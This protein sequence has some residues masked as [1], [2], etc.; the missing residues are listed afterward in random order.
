MIATLFADTGSL[1]R[2]LRNAFYA[3]EQSPLDAA[4]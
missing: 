2:V 4:V 1:R 3:H